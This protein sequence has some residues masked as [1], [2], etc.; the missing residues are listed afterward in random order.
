[1]FFHCDD[2]WTIHHRCSMEEFSVLLT[3]DNQEENVDASSDVPSMEEQ[4]EDP[5]TPVQHEV[6]TLGCFYLDHG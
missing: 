4:L 1:M 3:V 5:A 6:Y 2:K